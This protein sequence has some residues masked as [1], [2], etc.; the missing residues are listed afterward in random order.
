MK[1]LVQLDLKKYCLDTI[2]VL[3]KDGILTRDEFYSELLNRGCAEYLAL[4]ICRAI[5]DERVA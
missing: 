1:V 5:E 2:K 3:Y 4:C